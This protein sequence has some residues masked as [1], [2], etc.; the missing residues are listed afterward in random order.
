MGDYSD[1]EDRLKEARFN[2]A[3]LMLQVGNYADAKPIFEELGDFG[4]A[5][6]QVKACDYAEAS[7]LYAQGKLEE[8]AQLYLSLESYEDALTRARAIWY[9]LGSLNAESGEMLTAARYYVKASGYQDAQAQAD[10]L[11]DEYYGEPSA[12][13]Q[14]AYDSG[15]YMQ[16]EALLRP[17]D[18]TDLPA[19]YA[20]LPD[21]YQ[22]A[23][24]EAGNQLYDAGRPYAALPYYRQIPGYRNVDSRLQHSCYLI[25]GVWTDLNGVT[26]TFAPDGTLTIGDER[27]CFA[28]GGMTLQ[29]GATPD[30]LSDTHRVSGVTVSNAWLFDTRGGTEVTIYLTKDEAASAAL[31]EAVAFPELPADAPMEED[32]ALPVTVEIPIPGLDDE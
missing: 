4:S 5:A 30:A 24:Y 15:R 17:L 8:A 14:Q 7:D 13:A 10:A 12:Q 25:L 3:D 23:C 18:M 27:L 22:K 28:L 6:T 11:Y 26:Y 16:S 32:K 20:F 29:T 19:R 9:E 31:L 21:P 2:Q 1:S